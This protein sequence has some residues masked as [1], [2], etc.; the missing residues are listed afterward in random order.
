MK[1]KTI[2]K[3]ILLILWILIIFSF[4]FQASNETNKTS[5]TF[6]KTI[7]NIALKITNTYKDDN[8]VNDIVN[9]IHPIIRKLAH[10]TEFLILGIFTLLLFKDFNMK[11]V[12]LYSIIFCLLIAISDESIQLFID[13][14]AGQIKDILIDILGSITYILFNKNINKLS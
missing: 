3:I 13:G 9:K 7:V 11:Y 10:Y 8:Q 2:I 4:S 1:N 12:Y 6:T 5:S 14:R